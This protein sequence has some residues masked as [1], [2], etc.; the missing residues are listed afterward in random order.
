MGDI[1]ST[2][3]GI[4]NNE[5]I[6]SVR[7]MKGYYKYDGGMLSVIEGF[8]VLLRGIISSLDGYHQYDGEYS[9]YI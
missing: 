7:T 3:E 1:F 5:G 2:V 8:S 9:V 4:Q 6:S